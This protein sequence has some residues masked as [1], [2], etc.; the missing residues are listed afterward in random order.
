MAL[1]KHILIGRLTYIY[2]A[3]NKNDNIKTGIKL[4]NITLLVDAPIHQHVSIGRA[5]NTFSITISHP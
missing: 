4:T 2:N 3:D 1:H 5:K